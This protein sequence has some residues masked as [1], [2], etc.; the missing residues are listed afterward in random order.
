MQRSR[1]LRLWFFLRRRAPCLPL[2]AVFYV[3]GGERDFFFDVGL[4]SVVDEAD[5]VARLRGLDPKNG[6]FSPFIALEPAILQG[7]VLQK[8]L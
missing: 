7:G 6:Y 2:D 1:S 5:E 3:L 8:C 4:N